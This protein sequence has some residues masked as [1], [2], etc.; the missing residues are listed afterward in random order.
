M[1]TH[2]GHDDDEARRILDLCREMDIGA[3][4][5]QRLAAHAQDQ[6][7]KKAGQDKPPEP[8]EVQQYLIPDWIREDAVD[9]L[10]AVQPPG[11]PLLQEYDPDALVPLPDLL[12]NLGLTL[13]DVLPMR[14]LD[15]IAQALAERDAPYLPHYFDHLVIP[16]AA[17]E[18]LWNLT[19][20]DAMAA[21][22]QEAP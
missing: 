14:Q 11:R 19:D 9:L 22:H 15:D 1:A 5:G 21:A 12:K 18:I 10:E 20:G 17:R 3:D 16:M 2:F 7:R 4:E 13:E 6:P 8:L